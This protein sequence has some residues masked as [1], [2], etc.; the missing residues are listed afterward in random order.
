MFG[1]VLFQLV[2]V[3]SLAVDSTSNS[4]YVF[5]THTL[6]ILLVISILVYLRNAKELTRFLFVFVCRR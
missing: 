1:V 2:H 5:I 6:S 4:G 3:S